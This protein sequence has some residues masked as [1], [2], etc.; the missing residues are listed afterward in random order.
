MRKARFA[1]A[2]L[3][4]RIGA[5]SADEKARDD[6]SSR[7]RV[8][9]GILQLAVDHVLNSSCRIVA[10][11]WFLAARIM[12]LTFKIASLAIRTLAK[13][14]GVRTPSHHFNVSHLI[15]TS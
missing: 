7:S 4:P 1:F 14:I 2:E 9:T 3:E 12:S 15:D 11:V 6:I 10:S 13:P 5:E 8:T